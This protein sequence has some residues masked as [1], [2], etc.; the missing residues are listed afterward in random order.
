MDK[1]EILKRAYQIKPV[2]RLQRGKIVVINNGVLPSRTNLVYISSQDLL[3]SAYIWDPKVIAQTPKLR[4]VGKDITTYHTYGHPSLFKP[5]VK[6]VLEQIPDGYIKKGVVAF[7]L[8]IESDNAKEITTKLCGEG[9]HRAKVRLYKVVEGEVPDVVKNE[10]ILY[11]K[12]MY[13]YDGKEI[14]EISS[15]NDEMEI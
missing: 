5:S 6:E 3:S 14:V 10:P 7:E 4:K 1:Q 9:V 2:M 13:G 12:K 11:N 15:S 8:Y